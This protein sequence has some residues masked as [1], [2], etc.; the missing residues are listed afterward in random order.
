[1]I[2]RSFFF[3]GKLD[4]SFVRDLSKDEALYFGSVER[5]SRPHKSSALTC[6]VNPIQEK[7][8]C[9]MIE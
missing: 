5:T 7:L 8:A 3:P 9:I 6:I 1:M 4:F 2:A